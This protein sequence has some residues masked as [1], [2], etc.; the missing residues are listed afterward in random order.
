MARLIEQARCERGA[1]SA[2][3]NNGALAPLTV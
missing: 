3:E 2:R 1:A